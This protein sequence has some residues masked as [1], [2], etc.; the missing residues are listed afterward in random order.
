MAIIRSKL[1]P[2]LLVFVFVV[3]ACTSS[4]KV[5]TIEAAF[6]SPDLLPDEITSLTLMNRAVNDEFLNFNKDSLQRYFYTE[7]F[8]LSSVV[9]DSVAADTTLKVLGELL[10][11]SG[12]YDVVIPVDRNFERDIKF[13]RL[14]ENL[15]WNKVQSICDEFETDAL[16]VMERFYNKMITS[17]TI[18]P[19]NMDEFKYYSATID[20]K[21]DAIFKVY[22]PKTKE[23]VKQ[24]IVA[25]TIS[26]SDYD[27]SP[28]KLFPKL[29]SIKECL[30][31][32]G[33]KVALDLDARLSPAWRSE[34]RSYFIIEKDDAEKI[35]ALANNNDW[36][37][38]YDY[39]LDY[40]ES[41]KTTVK[42]KA[43]YNL[44]LASEMLGDVNAAIEWATKSYYTKYHVQTENYLYKLKKRK[45]IMERFNQA[46]K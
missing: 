22:Y 23:I 10:Y 19:G 4:Y 45:E 8:N 2:G 27:L 16:L 7:G 11:E 32:T 38:A 35:S 33:I 41:P 31:Q 37:A 24:L 17:Y 18:H 42:S 5:L 46:K 36:Q 15:D 39:W 30:I 12:R 14:P 34:N 44:A 25:D 20:S 43:E 40:A 6:P 9:L 1:L 26:W 13:Y 3:T 21:Y 28:E 29:P